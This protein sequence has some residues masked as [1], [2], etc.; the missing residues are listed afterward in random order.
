M[1]TEQFSRLI[2]AIESL[3]NKQYTIS[4][5]ADWPMLIAIGSLLIA[6]IGFMWIDLRSKLDAGRNDTRKEFD[7]IWQ[8]MKDCQDDC[9]PRTHGRRNKGERE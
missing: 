1:T 8:A 5:A 9:C 2:T 3:V 7:A 6:V 4:G